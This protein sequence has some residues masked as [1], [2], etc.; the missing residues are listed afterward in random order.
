[1]Q[2]PIYLDHA[3]T[4]PV[5]PEVAEAMMP[6]L[7]Q[8]YANPSAAHALGI[9]ARHAVEEARGIVAEAIHAYPDE[10]VFTSGGTESDN[11]AIYGVAY[12]L[13][14]RGRHIL[15]S[16]IE[17]HAVLEPLQYLAQRGW[18]IEML[19]VSS[20][21]LVAPEEVA[22]RIR[23]DTVLVSVMHAN[24]E[25]G[26]VQPIEAIGAICRE[27][28]VLFH[29]DAVQS[30]GYLPID[31]RK[32]NIDLLSLTAHK[33][34]GPK[35]IG[36]L[37]VRSGIPFEPYQKGGGQE[38]GRRG[39]TLNVPGIVGLGKAVTMV[40]EQREGES[41][42]LQRLRDH[43]IAAVEQAIPEATLTG[44]RQ[45]RL[46]N[47]VHFCFKGIEGES[48]LLSLDAEGICAS[49]GAACSAGSHEPSHVLQAIGVPPDRLRGA[50]RLSLGR[51]TTEEALE[52]C[53][54]VLQKAVGA[55][56]QKQRVQT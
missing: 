1:M 52:Y 55:L 54:H 18:E 46:P 26:T 25:I 24:N 31:V 7:V 38:N 48:L 56:R 51:V 44:H 19:P 47:N 43:F 16:P 8:T 35:G 41:A 15:S 53:L 27:K 14:N 49:A 32:M 33:F 4:T 20:E 11:A 36:V 29:T 9:E 17:H 23:N 34:Y 50:L 5:L 12:A 13:E 28:G 21:G 30:F 22:R 3:A 42:R 37:Y 6:F 10:I 39:G 45:Y 40:M 2:L